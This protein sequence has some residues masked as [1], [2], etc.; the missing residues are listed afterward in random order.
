MSDRAREL[1]ETVIGKWKNLGIRALS[2]EFMRDDIAKALCTAEQRGLNAGLGRAAQLIGFADE[3]LFR[4]ER[5]VLCDAIRAISSSPATD[6]DR[7]KRL[8]GI[9]R[10]ITGMHDRMAT[11]GEYIDALREARTAIVEFDESEAK[12]TEAK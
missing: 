11:W 8:I 5:K 6:T 7:E 2:I 4:G 1:A 10:T 12:R 3:R 9:L